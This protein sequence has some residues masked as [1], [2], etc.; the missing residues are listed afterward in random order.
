[1]VTTLK[2]GSKEECLSKL[3]ERLNKRSRRGVNVKKYV[4]ILKMDK[5]PLSIQ[6][7]MRNDWE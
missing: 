4:G 5:D 3:I 2:Y 6:K 7:E 1:M